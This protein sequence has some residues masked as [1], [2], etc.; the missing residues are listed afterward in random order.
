MGQG[1]VNE[2]LRTEPLLDTGT[3]GEGL[4]FLTY[5]MVREA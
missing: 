5:E 2:A 1:R 3:V 4:A